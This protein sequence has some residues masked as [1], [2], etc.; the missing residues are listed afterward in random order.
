MRKPQWLTVALALAFTPVLSASPAEGD[1]SKTYET[2]GKLAVLHQG[3]IKPLDTVA[4][5]TVKLVYGKETIQFKDRNGRLIAKWGPVAAFF[6]WSVRPD[7][8]DQQEFILVDYLPLKRMLLARPI[9]EMLA[10]IAEKASTSDKA[11]IAHLLDAKDLSASD[12]RGLARRITL[13][14]EDREALETLAGKLSEE[15]RWLSPRDLQDGDVTVEGKPV[16]F[17]RWIEELSER[18]Q[19]AGA[20]DGKPDF[21]DLEKRGEE[22]GDRFL[23]YESVRDRSETFGL[24]LMIFPHP[25]NAAFFTFSGAALQKGTKS[26]DAQLT[27]LELDAANTLARFWRDL[28]GDDRA[29]PGQDPK[30]DQRYTT[31]LKEDAAWVPLRVVLAADLK[32][33]ERAGFPVDQVVKFRQ[34]FQAMEESERAA[35]NR[36]SWAS[37]AALVASARSLGEALNP[38]KY[39]SVAA[40][41]RETHFNTV[42]P[43]FHAPEAY[44]MGFALLVLSM[45]FFSLG[46]VPGSMFA[47]IGR[48]AYLAGLLGF[49][50]GIALEVYGFY[51]RVRISGWA[52]VTNM[53]ETVIWVGLITAVLGL[54]FEL[55]FKTVYPALA[56][57]GV[58][59]LA[60]VLAANVPLLDPNIKELP[61]VLRSNYWLT[62]H[63][64]TE[65]SSY[66][67]FALAMGLGL[68]ATIYYLTATYRRAVCYVELLPPLVLGVPMLA[69][70]LVGWYGAGAEGA[71]AWLAS[72][73]AVYATATV[74][75]LG[76][77]LSIAAVSTML[78]ELTS[79]VSFRERE[80]VHATEAAASLSAGTSAP[81]ATSVQTIRV[82][83]GEG[84]GA[85]AILTRPTIAEIRARA[86][87]GRVALDPRAQAMQETAAKIKPI[88]NAIYRGMQVGVLLIAAGT[89]LGG[90]W[91]DVSWGRFWGWDSK[92]VWALITLLVYLVPLHG[93]F[94]G[95]FNTFSLVVASVVCFASVMMA[96]Y[97]VN[98]VLGVGLHSYG[99]TE[100]GGQGI[101]TAVCLS[102]VA[103]VAGAG[104]RRFLSYH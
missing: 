79:R 7:Y 5:Q 25:T 9:H 104:W 95:W 71:P 4:R 42:A 101:V 44:G 27:P 87:S 30:F 13:S 23:I 41:D 67:A 56:A 86:V 64:L 54:I 89:M 40:I 16:P 75:Y 28:P 11:T 85:V 36:A 63:V 20:M 45:V 94:A 97:G 37:A 88:A 29:L 80:K 96:W 38:E 47:K 60:T 57:S 22:V 35:P 69:L 98:F 51:L 14:A 48:W 8:W 66:A 76:G 91:A 3:R 31:Y 50:T 74:A 12:L 55:I 17:R 2:L 46:S 10:A 90:F 82:G 24:P 34:A 61:P 1:A 77:F 72:K 92:E 83:E 102:V 32:E 52:P 73:P 6:D 70:G 84:E 19:E 21:N 58:S 65:V 99:F 26:R 59:L 62:I 100:G 39:P 33:I 53:Y 18:S 93:R 103:V 43:F 15:H 49:I 68:I 78:G 81:A